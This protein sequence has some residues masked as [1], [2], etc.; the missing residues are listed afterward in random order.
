MAESTADPALA[1]LRS[2]W[3]QGW[4]ERTVT[5]ISHA[6]DCAAL[7]I[8]LL[9]APVSLLTLFTA[10]VAAVGL[11]V[12]LAPHGTTANGTAIALPPITT[13][14]DREHSAALG[15]AAHFQ[16]KDGFSSADV[17][18]HLGIM[19]D[20]TIGRMTLPAAG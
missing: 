7:P 18:P 14:A 4:C 9:P 16:T 13:H 17:R 10:L 5:L 19:P 11:A 12:R 6:G 2:G 3:C 15:R 8:P 1:E 20:L